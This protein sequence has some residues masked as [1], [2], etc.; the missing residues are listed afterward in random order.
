MSRCL[1][2]RCEDI[3][4]GEI[5]DAIRRGLS[6]VEEL[7][8]FTAFS[9]GPCQGKQCVR[10]VQQIL[11]EETGRPISDFPI[12]TQRSPILPVTLGALVGRRNPP[13]G[14]R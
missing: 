7:K 10:I 2:C 6:D 9:T 4:E 3:S 1:A 8:R 5:R 14:G 12:P 13:E 11:A